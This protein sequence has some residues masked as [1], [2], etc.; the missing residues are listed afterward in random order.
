MKPRTEKQK[1]KSMKQ[2]VDTLKISTK[3]RNL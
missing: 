3:L 2:E 1:N